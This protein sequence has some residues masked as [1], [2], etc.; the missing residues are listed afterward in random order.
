M[1]GSA[2]APVPAPVWLP[3]PHCTFREAVKRF[4][5]GYVRF[6]SRS[7]RREY[8]YAVLFVLL[9]GVALFPLRFVIPSLDVLWGGVTTIPLLAIGSRRLH[10]S[11]R[12]ATA[13]AVNV[14]ISTIAAGV[15]TVSG[16]LSLAIA[17]TF[18]KGPAAS[19]FDERVFGVVMVIAF[20]GALVLIAMFIWYLWLMTR[21]S[22]PTATRWDR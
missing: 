21:P 19:P 9:V 17:I 12:R 18:T 8:W 20:A 13:W 1:P 16:I 7:S 4:F 14:V 15:L 5:T 6:D 10:D 2:P 11:G 22:D 3:L